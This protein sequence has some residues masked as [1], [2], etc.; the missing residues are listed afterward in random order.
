MKASRTAPLGS[1]EKPALQFSHFVR[2]VV[3]L[4]RHS[5]ALTHSLGHDQSRAPS[6]GRSF[7]LHLLRYYWPLGL[8]LGTAPFHLRLIEAAFAQ[9][10]PPRRVSPVPHQAFPTCPLPCPGSVL[11]PSGL[12]HSLLPSP[13]NDRLGRSTFRL[14]LFS[15]L[16]EFTLSHWARRFA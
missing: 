6:L 10:G 13:G 1:H 5:L 11:C 4:L 12:K 8:P 3:S 9:C 7:G 16:Q 2:R 15:R 14:S